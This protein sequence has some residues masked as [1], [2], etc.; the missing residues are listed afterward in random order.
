MCPANDLRCGKER[1]PHPCEDYGDAWYEAA[2]DRDLD[3]GPYA[4]VVRAV[5]LSE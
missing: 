1:A 2:T 3:T 4:S 5:A